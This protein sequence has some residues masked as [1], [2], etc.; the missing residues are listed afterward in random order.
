[1]GEEDCLPAVVVL[2]ITDNSDNNDK[3]SG[4]PFVM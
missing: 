2:D 3:R 4:K 1:M